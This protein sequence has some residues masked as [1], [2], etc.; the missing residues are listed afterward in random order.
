MFYN[1]L[2]KKKILYGQNQE[3]TSISHGGLQDWE[4][5]EAKVKNVHD[6]LL[7]QYIQLFHEK[8]QANPRFH[9]QLSFYLWQ[10]PTQIRT[11]TDA[12][13]CS[14]LG[15]SVSL[16]TSPPPML[17]ALQA[18][19]STGS[20]SITSLPMVGSVLPP[21]PLLASCTEKQGVDTP[22]C[23]WCLCHKHCI[24]C[25]LLLEVVLLNSSEYKI[26]VTTSGLIVPVNRLAESNVWRH[27]KLLRVGNVS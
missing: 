23:E 9:P 1:L 10:N 22:W 13:T 25:L 8:P 3:W 4:H 16:S 6:D 18:Y 19:T 14:I 24:I 7:S 27:V 26:L 11:Q 2:E 15:S 5:Q 20:S 17:L 12:G 21:A